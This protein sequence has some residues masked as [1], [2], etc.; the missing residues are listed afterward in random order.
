M[1]ILAIATDLRTRELQVELFAE[2]FAFISVVE[3]GQVIADG[4]VVFGGVAERFFRQCEAGDVG[5]GT[6]VGAHLGDQRR[7]VGGVGDDGDVTIVLGRRAHHG[8]AA[9]V[10]V[11]DCVV[12]RVWL[13][14]R[15]DEGIEIHAHQ[16]DVGHAVRCHGRDVLWQIAPRKNAAV[17]FRMQR[18][19]AAV[20]HLG[21]TG[22]FA[23]VD[24][25]ES[26]IAQRLGRAA[27]GQEFNTGASERAG[28]IDEA[29][30][31][32]HGKQGTLNSHDGNQS[33]RPCSRIFLRRVLRLMPSM[34][35]ARVWLP[36]ARSRM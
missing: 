16:I 19:D 14:H 27:G 13:R 24:H 21:E 11:L 3:R 28:E 1:R 5:Q 33:E 23:D 10:D 35:A 4:A 18:L 6:A 31:V 36:S 2:G 26:G 25:A 22:V 20:E 15:G 12:E 30:F 34:S 8:R 29:G 7:V 32:R 17:D 9:D